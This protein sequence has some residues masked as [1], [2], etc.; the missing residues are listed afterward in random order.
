MCIDISK[1]EEISHTEVSIGF[2]KKKRKI[3]RQ[4]ELSGKVD[5]RS[6]LD[7]ILSSLPAKMSGTLGEEA[8][9]IEVDGQYGGRT[10][11]L[12]VI[13]TTL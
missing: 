10:Q 12:G 9:D 13:S 2:Q 6:V 1:L 7:V 5:C 3:A 8:K 11:D 4:S